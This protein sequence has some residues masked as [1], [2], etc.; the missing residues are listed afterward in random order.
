M[1]T[2]QDQK[3]MPF[4]ESATA[5]AAMLLDADPQADPALAKS[6]A[7]LAAFLSRR[8]PAS[9]S[10][11]ALAAALDYG[12]VLATG[13]RLRSLDAEGKRRFLSLL[14]RI[15]LSR[16]PLWLA[17]L[18]Y[19]FA[20]LL[21]EETQLKAGVQ[22]GLPAPKQIEP[23]RWHAQVQR[24]A[25]T[26]E[27]VEIEAEAVVVGTGAG[28]AAAAYELASRGVATAIVEAGEYYDRR[29]FDG[30]YF[31]AF[32]KIYR[33]YQAV[34]NGIVSVVAGES[35][36]GATTINAG[37]CFRTPDYVL[38]RWTQSG[39]TDFTPDAMDPYFSE[40][41][42]MLG[43]EE[44]A[45]ST[46]GPLFE[47]VK[48]GAEA[49]G[50]RD[51][52]VL[53]R[54]APGCDGQGL[55]AFGCPTDAKR[56]TNV[57]Y[58]P[59]ALNAGAFLYAGFRVERLLFDG[60]RVV[61]VS[62]TG[63]RGDGSRVRLTIRAPHVVVAMGTIKT[64]IFL[65]EQGVKNQHLGRHLTVHPA[66][67]VSGIF[68]GVDFQNERVI[69]QAVGI[70]DLSRKGIRFEGGTPPL[71]VYGIS[72]R[73]VGRDYRAI[74]EKYRNTAFLGFMITDQGEGRVHRAIKGYPL[75][76]YKVTKADLEKCVE[77]M[78]T[79]AR[80]FLR[81]GAR[82]VNLVTFNKRETILRSEADVDRFASGKW[83]ARHFTLT[84]YHPLGTARITPTPED[85]VCDSNHQVFGY[86]GLYVM[87]GSTV[88][89]PLGV[90]PQITIMAMS[91]RAARALAK[92]ISSHYVAA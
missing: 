26:E 50:F 65:M 74:A 75:L 12:A 84:A 41:E 92:K 11:G 24:A 7:D 37:T 4:A 22:Y 2:P 77:A 46:V 44:A 52:H 89:S 53:R 35:V 73:V 16:D 19:K 36:G 6:V 51:A 9:V 79:I 58:I 70:G 87:D 3:N 28:G 43:V 62:G 57:S 14:Q 88:P 30:K 49:L 55:C 61:G 39:L 20:Y 10:L 15:P 91:L 29:H 72:N 81:A 68:E 27:D 86:E 5:V 66:G 45:L 83:K 71:G 31:N 64:P 23:A 78:A 32:E 90:N 1:S 47:T 13:R 59:A 21:R 17:S 38:D 56:S 76:T 85:G 54:N 25:D 67:M 60:K 63:K 42:Q 34:G 48:R 82:E 69:P 40:V 8:Q 18:P 80:V 33:F